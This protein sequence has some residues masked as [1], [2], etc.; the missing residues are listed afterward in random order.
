MSLKSSK[1]AT[2]MVI[3]RIM[4]FLGKSK[5]LSLTMRY[6]TSTLVV[7]NWRTNIYFLLSHSLATELDPSESNPLVPQDKSSIRQKAKT[8]R[9]LIYVGV[10]NK[11]EKREVII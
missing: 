5:S 3:E 10:K 9:T 4:T 11:Y 6:E 2:K 8:I 7:I 1:N